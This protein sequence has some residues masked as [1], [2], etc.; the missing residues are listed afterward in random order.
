[1]S[2]NR[3]FESTGNWLFKYRSFLPLFIIPFL[4]YLLTNSISEELECILFYSGII[5]SFLGE[6]IRIFTVAYTPAGTS[7]RNT[8]QQLADTLNTTGIYSLLRHPLYLGNFFMFLGPFIFT[9]NILGISIFILIFCLYYERIMYAEEAFLIRK[10]ENEY[11]E[12]ASDTP[13]LIPKISAFLPANSKF[14][15]Q[16]V[17]ER[18]YS[19]LCAVIVIFTLMVGFRNFNANIHPILSDSWK[20]LFSLNALLYIL[21][22]SLKKIRRYKLS[23]R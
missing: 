7:G 5:I 15:F 13:A 17:M 21:L 12:W 4:F 10:F 6:G 14:S 16:K 19:G 3:E 22:R 18:E 8:K 11:S 9:G 1:M 23:K 20:L 2:L